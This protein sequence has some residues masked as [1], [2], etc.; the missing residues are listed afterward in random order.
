MKRGIL[1]VLLA[2]GT[3]IMVSMMPDIIRYGKIKS[4]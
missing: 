4:M 3:M 2:L 1:F